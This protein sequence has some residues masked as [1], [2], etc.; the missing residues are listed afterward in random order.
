MCFKNKLMHYLSLYLSKLK[1]LFLQWWAEQRLDCQS[2]LTNTVH[3]QTAEFTAWLA[4]PQHK[5]LL[6][7]QKLSYTTELSIYLNAV[8]EVLLIFIASQNMF[9]KIAV[10]TGFDQLCWLHLQECLCISKKCLV[11]RQGGI[12]QKTAYIKT[13]AIKK[14]ALIAL[15][16]L[17]LPF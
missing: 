17:K 3:F 12:H 5:H 10:F 4:P 14:T 2:L 9:N 7:S 16:M 15:P 1:L 11:R 6:L 8:S 13:A